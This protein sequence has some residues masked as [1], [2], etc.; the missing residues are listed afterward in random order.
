MR[1]RV[2]FK[3]ILDLFETKKLTKNLYRMFTALGVKS[4]ISKEQ[5]LISKQSSPRSIAISINRLEKSLSESLGLLVDQRNSFLD[6]LK[7]LP[8]AAESDTEAVT[9]ERQH[10]AEKIA[11]T[12]TEMETLRATKLSEYAVLDDSIGKRQLEDME[13]MRKAAS[14]FSKLKVSFL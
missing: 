14:P 2:F 10:L 6:Q 5:E 7:S 1:K 4:S 3:H 12:D 11:E 9:N 8:P 13:K